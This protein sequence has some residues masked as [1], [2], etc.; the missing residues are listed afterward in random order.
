MPS[1]TASQTIKILRELFVRFGI[2]QQ[3]VLDNDPQFISDEFKQFMAANKIKH[4]VGCTH[5][6][7]YV[8]RDCVL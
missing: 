3:L 6:C 7:I 5:V 8:S 1:A 2:P 4:V